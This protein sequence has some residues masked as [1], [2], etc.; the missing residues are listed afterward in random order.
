MYMTYVLYSQ[1]EQVEAQAQGAQVTEVASELLEVYLPGSSAPLYMNRRDFDA[2]QVE[3]PQET[4]QIEEM[5]LD[6]IAKQA[7]TVRDDFELSTTTSESTAGQEVAGP[8]HGAAES[9]QEAGT[10]GY[11]LSTSSSDAA[12]ESIRTTTEKAPGG[13]SQDLFSSS[14]SDALNVTTASVK[15]KIS[16]YE[17][18]ETGSLPSLSTTSSSSVERQQV[19]TPQEQELKDMSNLPLKPS[20]MSV[21]PPIKRKKAPVQEKPNSPIIDLMDST[22]E[23]GIFGFYFL[24]SPYM[25][26]VNEG[27]VFVVH[28]LQC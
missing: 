10:Q 27:V 11:Q 16:M 1:G 7:D 23:V 8:S 26:R 18:M 25:L 2:L 28:T 14:S 21:P 3:T 9:N 5:T 12:A 19:L 24:N 6:D 4:Q 13:K 20:D 15:S 22:P 17:D